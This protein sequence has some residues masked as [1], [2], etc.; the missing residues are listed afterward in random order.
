MVRRRVSIYH[1]L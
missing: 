1:Y